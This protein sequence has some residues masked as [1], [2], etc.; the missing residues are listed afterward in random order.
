MVRVIALLLISSAVVAQTPRADSLRLALALAANPIQEVDILNELSYALIDVDDSASFE[1]A[2]RAVKKAAEINYRKGLKRAL[3]YRGVGFVSKGNFREGI[4]HF[5]ASDTI[6]VSG[7]EEITI[8]AYNMIS[9]AYRHQGILDSALMYN[10]LALQQARALGRAR[11][12]A[13]VLKNLALLHLYRY[14]VSE[15]LEALRDAQ[16]ELDKDPENYLQAEVWSAQGRAYLMMFQWKNADRYFQQ[17]CSLVNTMPDRYLKIKCQINLSELAAQK[18]EYTRALEHAF[19]AIKQSENYVNPPQQFE[20]YQL[21]GKIYEEMGQFE[22]SA[23]Y[24]FQAVRIAEQKNLREM[25]GRAFSELAWVYKEM[26][27]YTKAHEYI[28]RSQVIREEI[29]D[30]LGIA[31]CHNVRGLIFLLEQKYDEAMRELDRS[32]R[33]REE[34]GDLPGIAATN[35]NLGLVYEALGQTEKALYYKKK[36]I[37]IED[38]LPNPYNLGISL[39]GIVRSLLN[40]GRYAEARTYLEKADSLVHRLNARMLLSNHYLN[41]AEYYEKTGNASLALAYFKKHKA[42][43]DSLYT[44]GAAT[45]IAEMEALFQLEAREQQI[46]ILEQNMK[47]RESELA[48]RQA[49]VNNLRL[50]LAAGLLILVLIIVLTWTMYTSNKRLQQA[51]REI[52]EQHE[53]IQTQAEELTE[54]NRTLAN[55]NRELKEK[56]EEIQAQAEELSEANQ[57]IS[58]I[59][60]NLES[61]VEKRTKELRQAY[62]ELD[63]F[64]YRSSHDFRRPLTT[65]MGLAEVARITVKDPAALELFEKVRDTAMALDKMLIKLQSISDVGTQE[66]HYRSVMIKEIFD[67]VCDNYRSEIERKKIIV[68]SDVQLTRPFFSYPVL[69][70]VILENL[71]ENSIQFC[72]MIDPKIQFSATE[73]EDY[74]ILEIADNGHGIPAEYHHQI[75]EMY[76]RGS[77]YSKGNGLGLY[78]VK[79]AVEKLSGEIMFKSEVDRGTVF[80]IRLPRNTR[81]TTLSP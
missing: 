68:T 22:L 64:F 56:Q 5:R 70:K 65:F 3:T 27:N 63:T 77:H 12:V 25:L 39:N 59:N 8:D 47:L 81:L 13:M 38:Q 24:F 44:V 17:M 61:E 32:L 49:Q 29:K 53:E 23:R 7:A 14:N 9:N 40:L 54:A 74:I 57:T 11:S 30:Q 6:R 67:A 15:S 26:G 48:L 60:R 76:F 4:Q 35:F 75:F 1:F 36:C 66:L 31:N 52:K 55:L 58:Q 71:L 10:Q 46:R 45:R 21:L 62:K 16:T 19:E 51:N 42:M 28:D 37:E 18:G 2:S 72:S 73:S 43:F 50:V 69:I 34:I 79:K 80:S 20:L 78:I 41:Y 33:L